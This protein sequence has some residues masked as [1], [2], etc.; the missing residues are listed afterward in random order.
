MIKF[1]FGVM[2]IIELELLVIIDVINVLCEFILVFWFL[3]SEFEM[4]LCVVKKFVFVM[5][6]NCLFFD[7]LVVWVKWVFEW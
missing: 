1:V 2:L 4:V 3:L 7:N 5:V 6:I